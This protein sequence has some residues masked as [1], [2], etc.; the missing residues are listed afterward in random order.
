MRLGRG[1]ALLEVVLIDRGRRGWDWQVRDQAGTVLH[2]GREKT[3]LAAKYTGERT[4]FQVL[5]S[6]PKIIDLRKLT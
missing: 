4:L 3:R 1:N 6:D 2:A 5:A